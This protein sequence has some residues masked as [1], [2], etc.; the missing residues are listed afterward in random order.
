MMKKTMRRAGAV[1]LSL[2]LVAGT[3]GC[4]KEKTDSTSGQ[5]MAAGSKGRYVETAMELPEGVSAAD[6]VQIGKKDGRLFFLHEV[7]A[8]EEHVTFEEYVLNENGFEKAEDSWIQSLVLPAGLW[9][10]RSAYGPD[11]KSFVYTQFE[12]EEGY[13]GH[14]YTAGEGN[15][16]V[17][18]TP[19]SWKEKQEYDGYAY[20]DYPNCIG[21][22]DSDTLVGVFY[23]RMEFYQADTG[24]MTGEQPVSGN[25]AEQVTAGKDGFYLL[26]CTDMGSFDGVEKYQTGQSEPAETIDF[27][28]K[29][30][31]SVFCDVLNDGTIIV[32]ADTGFYQW[33]K[34][35][36]EWEKLIPVEF[37]S[38]AME[39][40][41]CQSIAAMEDGT[42]YAQYQA[43]EE[44]EA[45]L[46][47]YVYDPELATAPEKVLTVYTIYECP[48][49]KQSAAMFQKKHPEVQVQVETELTYDQ[50]YSDDVDMNSIYAALNAKILAGEAADILVLD[51]MN[52]NAFAEKKLLLDIDDVITPMEESGELLRNITGSYRQADG[53]RYVVPLRFGLTLLV[54]RDVDAKTIQSMESMAELFSTM[55]ESVLGVRTVEDLAAEFVPFF[56]DV[57]VKNKELDKEALEHYLEEL[58]VI[59]TNCGIVKDYGEAYRSPG[60]WEIASTVQAAFYEADGFNQTMLPV[61]AAK[62][63]NGTVSCFENAYTP[64]AQAAIYSQT[65]EPELAKEFLQ[66][67]L[68]LEIQKNDFY[69]GFPVNAD[70]LEQQAQRDRSDATAYTTIMLEDGSSIGFEIKDFDDAQKEQLVEMC[71]QADRKVLADEEVNAKLA[72]ALAGYLDGSKSLS[73]TVNQ[74][75]SGLRMYLAE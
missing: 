75:E 68:S 71:R 67:A 37:T 31:S 2:A 63:V 5:D 36:G 50:M 42:L 49:L 9:Q 48:V 66:F 51:G 16:A 6:I 25:H 59:G 14:L 52:Q 46:M 69:D 44:S 47:Q 30:D 29:A 74:V 41:W 28:E 62:L 60:I 18:I 45:A 72:D 70:A 39:T 27:T 24:E 17:E 61:S 8:D 57:I 40:M 33:K 19:Q 20:Y 15:Q 43:Q 3:V 65:K 23:D 11:G 4:G 53:A 32:T 7:N 34:E 64:K 13:I 56:T 38:L 10:F 1:L 55:S 73:E 58:K 54:G 22:A 35:T 26:S 21:F 12:A